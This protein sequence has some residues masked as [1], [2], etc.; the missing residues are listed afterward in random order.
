MTTRK[1]RAAQSDE[2]AHR[3]DTIRQ[4]ETAVLSEDSLRRQAT[5]QSIKRP[6]PLLKRVAGDWSTGEMSWTCCVLTP[7][8]YQA[9]EQGVQGL[10]IAEKFLRHD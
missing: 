7:G 8:N 6:A 10:L 1:S 9:E 3:G 5:L 4:N 2:A